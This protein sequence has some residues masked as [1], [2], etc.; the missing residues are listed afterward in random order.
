MAEL[1]IIS[2]VIN[3]YQGDQRVQKQIRSFRKFGFETEV[4]ATDLRGNPKLDFDYPVQIIRLSNQDGML[5]YLEFNRKLF[6]RL[7][8]S[9]K[10][11]DI[12]LAN[13]LD[14]LLPNYLISKIKKV[15]VVFDSHEIFSELPSLTGRKFKK[16]SWK[17]LESSLVPRMKHFYTVSEGYADWFEKEYGNRP[18]IIMNVPEIQTENNNRL[19]IEL[20][21][22]KENQKI[23]IYQGAINISRGI[24]KMILA[25]EKI[26]SAQLWIIGNG[27][28]KEEYQKLT[29]EKGLDSKVIFI[30]AV[31]PDQLK[32][33]TPKA[34]LG[35]SLEEDLGISYRYA[36]PN[37]IF[38]YMHAGV[39][40]LGTDLPDIKRT[41]ENYKIGRTVS[42]HTPEQIAKTA[43]EMLAEGKEIYS[44]NLRKATP[45][46]NWS[47]EEKKLEKIFS[48][49]ITQIRPEKEIL[50]R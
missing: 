12:L 40:V 47:N 50:S 34:D 14:S 11:G 18:E 35:F 48:E 26:E 45:V 8:K 49:F 44:E 6:G 10:K 19:Q 32:L 17:M 2:S 21:Q 43:N 1:R 16:K 5:M 23:L 39:P 46:F 31:P 42:D 25:M 7:M 4:I 20:P 37:K 3:N 41:I 36:L 22:T 30:S 27:P 9:V 13:D 24:D 28:K 38:D 33:I 15:P 29:S